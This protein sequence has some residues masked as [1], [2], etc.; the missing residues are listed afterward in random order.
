[1][2]WEEFVNRAQP[3]IA[4]TVLRMMT[5]WGGGDRP[6]ADDLT[7]DVLAKLLAQDCRVLRAFRGESAAS[8]EAYLRT[9]A[10]NVT[11]DYYRAKPV[12]AVPLEDVQFSACVADNRAGEQIERKLLLDR[13]E[14]CLGGQQERDRSIFWLYHRQGFSP[15]S[16]AALPGVAMGLSGVETLLY[17]LTKLVAECVK[18]GHSAAEGVSA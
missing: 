18:G 7:Q 6:V 17:R 9:V 5:R 8:L 11:T 4:A 1:V 16:I 10:A 13:V 3:V 14:R 2:D 12:P 15:K